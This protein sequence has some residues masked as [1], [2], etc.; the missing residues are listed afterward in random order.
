MTRSTKETCTIT[1]STTSR[2]IFVI[3]LC[4]CIGYE[5]I[6]ASS[7]K[8]WREFEDKMYSENIFG[9]DCVK[10]KHL[11]KLHSTCTTSM[12]YFF[13]LEVLH[14]RTRGLLGLHLSN[15]HIPHDCEHYFLSTCINMRVYLPK[16][17][18]WLIAIWTIVTYCL[19]IGGQAF[20]ISH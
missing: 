19:V 6:L 4:F 12:N 1:L 8:R 10:N 20:I 13:N 18:D 3:W 16:Y 7:S 14:I 9:L 17:Y 2:I 5:L 15:L 11:L